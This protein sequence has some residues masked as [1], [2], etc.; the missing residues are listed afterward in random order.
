[1]TPTVETKAA[2]LNTYKMLARSMK[3]AKLANYIEPLLRTKPPIPISIVE[4]MDCA[5][6]REVARRAQVNPP[7]EETQ[8]A[9]VRLLWERELARGRHGKTS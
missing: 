5:W 3:A 8:A 7:S 1:M 2:P 9:V 6:W 4:D